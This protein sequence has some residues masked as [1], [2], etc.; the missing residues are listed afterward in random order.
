M[1][2]VDQKGLVGVGRVAEL[3]RGELGWIFR[4]QL[5]SDFGIDAQIELVK[6]GEPT[7]KLVGVQIKTGESHFKRTK[8]GLV[9]YGE[10]KH[11]DYWLG[12][13]IPVILVAHL[14]DTKETFWAPIT[15]DSATRTGA[16]WKITLPFENGLG[17]KARKELEELFSGPPS[18]QFM[19]RL[20]VDE[21]LI[22]WAA[23]QEPILLD[24]EIRSNEA[25]PFVSITLKVTDAGSISYSQEWF[26]GHTD[27]PFLNLIRELFP[28]G[29]ATIDS[30]FYEECVSDDGPVS[31]SGA[32]AGIYP[33]KSVEGIGEWYRFAL[34]VNPIGQ[35]FANLSRH[36]QML[37][38]LASGSSKVV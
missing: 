19:R 16:L 24:V 30:D 38:N 15:R 5:I 21:G 34:R 7:G 26:S 10:R 33:Y 14:P 13:S 18:A 27:Q 1:V 31:G 37:D 17:D 29:N 11:L 3:V 35:S 8:R 12:S 23:E 6:D 28:W 9:Y 22:Q 4:E 20:K 36:L 2:T 32:R 25:V